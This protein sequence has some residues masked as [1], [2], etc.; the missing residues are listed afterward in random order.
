M[1]EGKPVKISLLHLV[2]DEDIPQLLEA[3]AEEVIKTN[4]II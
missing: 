1:T 2:M 3:M 4:N